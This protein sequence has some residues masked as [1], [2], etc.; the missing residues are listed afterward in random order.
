M[1]QQWHDLSLA[2]LADGPEANVQAVD[3]V[4]KVAEP[5][6]PCQVKF[7]L[8]HSLAIKHGGNSF[9]RNLCTHD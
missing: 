8:W 9:L 1:Q 5:S 7:S 2:I 4:G 6:F 3:Y